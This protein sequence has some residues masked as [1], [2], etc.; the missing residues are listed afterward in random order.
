MNPANTFGAD[1]GAAIGQALQVQKANNAA[2]ASKANRAARNLQLLDQLSGDAGARIEGRQTRVAERKAEVTGELQ[3]QQQEAAA[4]RLRKQLDA[5]D[6]RLGKRITAQDERLTRTLASQERRATT[7][8]TAAQTQRDRNDTIKGYDSAV[9]A[10][11]QLLS[12]SLTG[13]RE[14]DDAV[15]GV[16]ANR[17]AQIATQRAQMEKA[18]MH[19]QPLPPVALP[20]TIDP[21]GLFNKEEIKVHPIGYLGVQKLRAA[22]RDDAEILKWLTDNQLLIQ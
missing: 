17:Y 6:D 22:G 8:G 15:Y 11:N 16:L 19:P 12:R 4:D 13:A 21:P 10:Y 18:G 3:G 20:V 1:T 5:A 14:P 2:A 9:N 7:K